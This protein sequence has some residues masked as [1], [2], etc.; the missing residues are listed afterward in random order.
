MYFF[1]GSREMKLGESR[2]GGDET[3][4][5]RA[6]WEN[7][8]IFFPCISHAASLFL[9]FVRESRGKKISRRL[10]KRQAQ[11]QGD[12]EGDASTYMCSMYL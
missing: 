5:A 1:S 3:N 4:L 8:M 7:E 10:P 2:G 12:R 11:S 6:S 9:T